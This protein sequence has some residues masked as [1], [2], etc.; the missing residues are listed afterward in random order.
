VFFGGYA[1]TNS[2]LAMGI[3]VIFGVVGLIMVCQG[4]PR[5]PMVLGLVLGRLIERNLFISYEIYRF[6]FLLRPIVVVIIAVAVAV[7]LLPNIQEVVARRSMRKE[8]TVVARE[9]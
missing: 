8:E 7:L 1:D 5:P 9:K 2:Y 6:G 3:T 4:W